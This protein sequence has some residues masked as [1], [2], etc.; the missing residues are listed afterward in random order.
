[1]ARI[2][3]FHPLDHYQL[4][5]GGLEEQE[6]A[7]RLSERTR[8]QAMLDNQ[9]AQAYA[10]AR[11]NGDFVEPACWLRVVGYVAALVVAGGMLLIG[12][13]VL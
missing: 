10:I 1:M 11:W 3:H 6:V 8:Q 2:Q 5:S 7:D 12:V 13:T 9:M 4:L